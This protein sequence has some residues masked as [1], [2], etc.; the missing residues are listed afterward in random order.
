MTALKAYT[1]TGSG[2][3]V[4]DSASCA[5]PGQQQS[6]GRA[7][8]FT[9][10]T[11]ER[12]GL[13]P[14]VEDCAVIVSELLSNAIRYGLAGSTRQSALPLRLALLRRGSNVLCAISDPNS[15]PPVMREP[16]WLAESGRGLHIVDSLADSWGWT[17]PADRSGKTVWASVSVSAPRD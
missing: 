4:S 6:A 1:R 5:L 11:L 15:Q 7:R 9:Q 2:L 13:G 16:D 17:R 3:P 10:S 8:H 12:W 14:A